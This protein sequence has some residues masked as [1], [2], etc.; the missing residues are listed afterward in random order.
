M[1]DD[2]WQTGPL[3]Q[4]SAF[5]DTAGRFTRGAPECT[6]SV[7]HTLDTI[8]VEGQVRRPS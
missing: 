8:Q 7:D 1:V 5:A 3:V 2:D 6:A 4:Y